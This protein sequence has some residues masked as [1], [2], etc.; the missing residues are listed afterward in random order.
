MRWLTALLSLIFLTMSTLALGANWVNINTA[1][2]EALDTLPGIGPS[3][4]QAIIDYR[5]TYGPFVS[6]EQLTDVRGIGA[7]TVEKLRPHIS[8]DNT[9]PAAPAVTATAK[10][11]APAGPKVNLN[12][13]DSE[14]LQSLPG[15]GP[16]K[17]EAIIA[18]RTTTPFSSPEELMAIKGIGEKTYANLKDRISV[19]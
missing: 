7:A 14:V 8:L 9:A 2:I 11:T 6:L 15:I 17:A 18:Y 1:N 19:D 12:T 10:A 3:K 16:S 5:D 13:A 4:A